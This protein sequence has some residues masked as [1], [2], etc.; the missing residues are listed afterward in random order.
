MSLAA[1]GNHTRISQSS[2]LYPSHCNSN[3]VLAPKGHDSTLKWPKL[4]SFQ[5][6]T[7]SLFVII[8]AS[9]PELQ[10]FYS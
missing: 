7:F 5:I 6:V 1:A 3:A 4:V 9:H 8:T 2:S 10:K